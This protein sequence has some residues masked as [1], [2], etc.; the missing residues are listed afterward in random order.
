MSDNKTAERLRLLYPMTARWRV[1]QWAKA[2][3]K[4]LFWWYPKG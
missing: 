4:A 1:A 3:N 2:V